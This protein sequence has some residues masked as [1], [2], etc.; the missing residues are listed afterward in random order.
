MTI[1]SDQLDAWGRTLIECDELF[2]E[3]QLLVRINPE[4]YIVDSDAITVT[5]VANADAWDD[6]GLVHPVAFAR[7]WAWHLAAENKSIP[8][9]TN[10]WVPLVRYVAAHLQY[11]GRD[12]RDEFGAELRRLRGLLGALVNENGL[13]QGEAVMLSALRGRD[14][15]AKLRAW[16]RTTNYHL[17][18]KD[19][20]TI[21]PEL[22]KLDWQALRMRKVRCDEDIPARM[23]PAHWVASRGAHF[24]STPVNGY[25]NTGEDVY[26]DWERYVSL[27][28]M[29]EADIM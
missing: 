3:V 27:D 14:A 10:A 11:L 13:S 9:I 5:A 7:R 22:D 12:D 1:G 4:A 26:D 20:A 28:A 17:S 21:F 6:G 8:P 23:Y 25:A 15:R 29:I 24:D 18:R 2:R 16:A 19:L